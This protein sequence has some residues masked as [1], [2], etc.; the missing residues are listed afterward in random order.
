[1]KYQSSHRRGTDCHRLPQKKGKATDNNGIRVEDIKT[2]DGTT[3]EMIKQIV[4]EVTEQEDCAPETC[5]IIR[6]KVIHKNGKEK[7]VGNYRPELC[8]RFTICTQ[9]SYTT[10]FTTDLTVRNKRTRKGFDVNRKCWEWG[11]KTWASLRNDGSVKRCSDFQHMGKG[12]PTCMGAQIDL[13]GHI[14]ERGVRFK[15]YM[16]RV[17]ANTQLLENAFQIWGSSASCLFRSLIRA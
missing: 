9:Q 12:K 15:N 1:M 8:Q 14:D 6:F 7:D 10:D 11:I 3:K 16:A 13:D 4:N 5:R 17:E 2:C